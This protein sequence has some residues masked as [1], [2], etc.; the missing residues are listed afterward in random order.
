M[1]K[2][3]HSARFARSVRNEL[4]KKIDDTQTSMK[5]IKKSGEL[6]K[7][8]IKSST[9][10]NYAG[11]IKSTENPIIP[12]FWK[13]LCD[14]KLKKIDDERQQELCKPNIMAFGCYENSEVGDDQFVRELSKDAG[15]DLNIKFLTRIGVKTEGKIRPIKVVLESGHERYLLLKNLINLREKP[16][17]EQISIKEDLTPFERSIIRDWTDRANERNLKESKDSTIVWRVR[18]SPLKSLYLKKYQKHQK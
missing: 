9:K 18:G 7:Q 5:E 8:D 12:D 4:K 10:E 1:P 17:F 11:I 16:K 14:E 2:V 15:V 3:A 6:I 13:I